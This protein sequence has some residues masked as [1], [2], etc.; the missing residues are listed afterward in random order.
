M[1]QETHPH[2]PFATCLRQLAEFL[3]SQ[4]NLWGTGV[5]PLVFPSLLLTE[6][7]RD[8][9]LDP[10]KIPLQRL[11]L[12]RWLGDELGVPKHDLR[13]LLCKAKLRH[14]ERER[15]I[16][17]AALLRGLEQGS[18]RLGQRCTLRDETLA[19]GIGRRHQLIEP[20]D[21]QI[22]LVPHR[23]YCLRPLGLGSRQFALLCLLLCLQSQKLIQV[24]I[25]RLSDGN[26]RENLSEICLPKRCQTLSVA[27]KTAAH[28]TGS[29]VCGPSR[30]RNRLKRLI[31]LFSSRS[32]TR[33]QVPQRYVRL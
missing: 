25:E 4:V 14:Q 18:L 7:G 15:P 13:T 33:P 22:N 6:K 17:H 2:F 29:P 1:F 8:V 21:M 9:V 30:A 12:R 20:L 32:N 3:G 19:I 27:G 28:R 26:L 24:M 31:A 11:L 16:P 23:T 10:T 5:D